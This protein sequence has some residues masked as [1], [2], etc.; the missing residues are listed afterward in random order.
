[1]DHFTWQYRKQQYRVRLHLIV[2]TP[3]DQPRITFVINGNTYN[4][5]PTDQQAITAISNADRQQLLALLEAIKT[6]DT[7]SHAE[8]QKAAE[9][10]EILL[11]N[12]GAGATANATHSPPSPRPE[13]L[14]SGDADA[15]MARLVMEEKLNRKSGVTK[16]TVYKFAA[17]TAVVIILLTVIF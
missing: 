10:A 7:L 15:L 6:H 14:G 2:L 17:G 13:R 8:V 1:M 11:Q 3:M 12:R 4:L 5:R 16:N 9:R